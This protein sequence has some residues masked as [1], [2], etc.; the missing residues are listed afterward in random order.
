MTEAIIYLTL[1]FS[2]LG[3]VMLIMHRRLLA[4]LGARSL[5]QLWALLPIGGLTMLLVTLLPASLYQLLSDWISSYQPTLLMAVSGVS[6]QL[7]LFTEQTASGS[8]VTIMGTIWW[9]GVVGMWAI[10]GLDYQQ[11]KVSHCYRSQGLKVSRSSG[12]S[13]SISGL[14]T[15]TLRLPT[16]FAG[17]FNK[18]E[19]E[20]IIAHEL[21]HWRRGDLHANVV[22]WLLLSTQWFNLLAWKCYTR[23]R[24][25]Q[26]LACDADVLAR[27]ANPT[28]YANTLLKASVGVS[29]T[30]TAKG[31]RAILSFAPCS[32]HYIYQQRKVTMLKERIE[33]L[34][35]PHPKCY[36]PLLC[37]S[38]LAISAMFIWQLPVTA[39]P[40]G[41]A[42]APAGST[43]A[44]VQDVMPI[45]RINPK[46]PADAAA[47]GIEGFVEVSF[48][49]NER[50]ETEQVEVLRSQ[51][52]NTFDNEVIAAVK[53]WR[54]APQQ[55]PVTQKVR[56]EMTL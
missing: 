31:F 36:T 39:M 1:T 25:D 30:Q 13:P 14:I 6:S 46:Y 53:R 17:H 37:T 18:A 49:V 51:P 15:P 43:A 50:G 45:V 48:V 3:A 32:T 8:I 56:I 54:Y 35:K 10:L 26:E 16:D 5:Y 11:T 44:P 20:L 55:T 9:V 7:S 24:A 33:Q 23:F 22:A 47:A 21:M 34:N 2:V 29:T 19:R 4:W 28:R 41:N 40:A 27:H 52:E 42:I 12:F 38:V